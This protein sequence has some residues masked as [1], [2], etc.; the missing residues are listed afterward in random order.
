MKKQRVIHMPETKKHAGGKTNNF[1]WNFTDNFPLLR[2][3]INQK[4]LPL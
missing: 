4:L 1:L 3:L 2:S